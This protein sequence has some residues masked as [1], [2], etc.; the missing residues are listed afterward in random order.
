MKNFLLGFLLATGLGVGLW[1]IKPTPHPVSTVQKTTARKYQCPM[2]PTFV[3]DKPGDCPICGMKLVPVEQ[4]SETETGTGK[5]PQNYSCPMHPTF[6]SNK[7]GDCPICGMKLVPVEK[8]TSSSQHA[9]HG[10]REEEVG[11]PKNEMVSGYAPV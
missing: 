4:S 1:F 7:P 9:G 3:S 10:L 5:E 11:P 8:D 2:H 6:V